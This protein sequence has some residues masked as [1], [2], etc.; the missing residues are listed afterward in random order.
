MM[1][2]PLFFARSVFVVRENPQGIIFR[3]SV[4]LKLYQ[5]AIF[6]WITKKNAEGTTERTRTYVSSELGDFYEVRRAK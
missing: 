2:K 4:L 6:E 1:R 3:I 5:N